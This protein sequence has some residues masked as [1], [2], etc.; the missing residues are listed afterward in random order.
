MMNQDKLNEFKK[1]VFNDS[2][3]E[4]EKQEAFASYITA[5]TENAAQNTLTEYINAQDKDVL[6]QR[7]AQVLTTEENEFYNK[8]K[9]EENYGTKEEFAFP[10]TIVDRVFEDLLRDHPLLSKLNITYTKGL[11]RWVF[12][13]VTGVATWGKLNDKITAELTAGFEGVD[14]G[15]NKLSAFMTIPLAML[16]LG[17]TWLDRYVRTVL[18]EAVSVALEEAVVNGTGKDQPIGILRSTEKDAV[19][20]EQPLKDKIDLADY[21][22]QSFYELKGKLNKGRN[23]KRPNG[24]LLLVMHPDTYTDQFA[25][26]VTIQN[27]LGVWVMNLP[28]A[29]EIVE[30]FAVE[31]GVAVFGFGKDYEMAIGMAEKIEY[32]DEFKFLDDQRVYKTRLFAHGLSIKDGNFLVVTLPKV[33]NSPS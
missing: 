11:T 23:Y 13:N 9:D 6:I 4:D 18:S 17:N 21:T 16:E 1:Q 33:S 2:L 24:S 12:S 26:Q 3:T 29:V 31:V 19:N 27:A 22:A 20:G 8:I 25:G 14:A 28:I 15:L 30:S 7:G 10:A 32:S 5:V